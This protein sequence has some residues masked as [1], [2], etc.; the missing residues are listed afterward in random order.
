MSSALYEVAD[1]DLSQKEPVMQNLVLLQKIIHPHSPSSCRM[2]QPR[3]RPSMIHDISDGELLP[4]STS[5]HIHA[6]PQPSYEGTPKS[7]FPSPCPPPGSARVG[8]SD[9]L[10]T[11]W[12]VRPETEVGAPLMNPVVI[13]SFDTNLYLLEA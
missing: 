6:P 4:G 11:S 5:S 9:S 3:V 10:V 8:P 1:I 12:T 7:P 13:G 2:S